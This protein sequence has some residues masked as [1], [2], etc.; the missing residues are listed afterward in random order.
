MHYA[1]SLRHVSSAIPTSLFVIPTLNGV[2]TNPHDQKSRLGKAR[3]ACEPAW[4][5]RENPLPV[6][7]S[8]TTH[9]TFT[10]MAQQLADPSAELLDDPRATS[11]VGERLD[12]AVVDLAFNSNIGP[13]R[14]ST[15]TPGRS[16]T[17]LSWSELTKVS[18]YFYL[19]RSL[20]LR[21]SWNTYER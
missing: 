20:G 7:R 8:R 12:K 18:F 9:T 6:P 13:T 21:L 14:P 1:P 10:T 16:C 2:R 19:V 11:R 4:C 3:T 17:T 5:G 15:H